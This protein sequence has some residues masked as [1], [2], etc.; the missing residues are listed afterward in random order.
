MKLI[1]FAMLLPVIKTT[2][3]TPKKLCKDCKFFIGNEQRCM[4]FG[5]T[6][7]VTGQQDYNYASSV[8]HNNNECG[9]DAKY[10]EKNNFKFLT[11]PYYF[12]LKYWYWY[13]LIFTYSAWIYVTIHK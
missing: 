7:L 9:E 10:F 11:V 2:L 1:S 13:T 3:I 12:T 8:R 4:K 5:N 6:N